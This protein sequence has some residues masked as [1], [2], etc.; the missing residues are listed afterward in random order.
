MTH[1]EFDIESILDSC[2]KWQEY[3]IKKFKEYCKYMLG[4]EIK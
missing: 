1:Y 2:Y 3:Y 4:K